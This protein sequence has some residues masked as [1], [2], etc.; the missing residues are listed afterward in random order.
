MRVNPSN[1]TS[2]ESTPPDEFHHFS[3]CDGGRMEH[4]F[5]SGKKLGAS[6]VVAYQQLSVNKIVSEHFILGKK[7]VELARVRFGSCE[8]TNPD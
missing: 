7:P 3:V 6:S 2:V 5:V 4:D 8:E 1:S